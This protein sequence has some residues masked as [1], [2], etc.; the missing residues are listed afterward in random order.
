MKI[1]VYSI[2]ILSLIFVISSTS[3]AIII[4]HENAFLEP[5]P[6]WAIKSASDSLHIAY[7]HTSHGSQVTHGMKGLSEQSTKLNGYK[8]DFYCWEKYYEVYG[9]NPCLD[10]HDN[11]AP[12]DLGH[13]GDT[14]WTDQTRNYLLNDERAADINVVMWSW[15]GGCSDNTDTGVR[16]Y[17]HAMNSLEQDFPKITF[18]YMTGHLDHWNDEKVK[19]NNQSIRDYCIENNKV[20]Y[21]FADIESY[22]PDGNYFEFANDNCDYYDSTGVLLG[23]W[24]EEWQT[25]HE[26]GKDWYLC[27]SAHS[28]PL[29]AN[30]KAYAA[31]WLWARL[32]GWNP[33]FN[34]IE[35]TKQ[36]KNFAICDHGIISN[37]VDYINAD[38]VRWEKMS[39][40]DTIFTKIYDNSIYSGTN[41]KTL[42]IDVPDNSF[43]GY[44][45]KATIYLNDTFVGTN[46]VMLTV[47]KFIEAKTPEV[48]EAC[49]ENIILEG[50]DP[51]PGTCE[52]SVLSGD[53]NIDSAKI[54]NSTAYNLSFGENVFQYSIRNGLCR[55]TSTLK[56]IRFHDI[57]MLEQPQNANVDPGGEAEFEV[58]VDG[59]IELIQWYKNNRVLNNS[60]KYVGVNDLKLRV[61]N[62][63]KADTGKFYCEIT[64]YCNELQSDTVQLD[65]TVS[66][67]DITKNDFTIYPNPINNILFIKSNKPISSIYIF[68]INGGNVLFSSKQNSINISS[69]DPGIYIIKVIID[70]QVIYKKITKM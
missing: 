29:N 32:I 39:P 7:G 1:K 64:G 2:L 44:L 62:V 9:D 4:N 66:T 61:L 60:S 22:D 15:C 67:S 70:D 28:K 46:D 8:G 40:S 5:I 3:Q 63:E 49:T 14:T 53:S 20:L 13:N 50:A 17:L 33:N 12:G 30:R 36:P 27:S 58:K 59:E 42:K 21:D 10:L 45:F 56:V 31:W 51:F 19:H 37:S 6:E 38:S 23:N 54:H 47:N 65:I 26:H 34:S 25:S 24:A 69:L 16:A 52:W 55:D 57:T 48:V 35:I 41:L 68:N 43:D 18:V 11:F